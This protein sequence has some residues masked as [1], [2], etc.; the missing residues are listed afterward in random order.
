MRN[1]VVAI[2]LL[3]ATSACGA[4][5]VVCRHAVGRVY[6]AHGP[7]DGATR[8][9]ETDSAPDAVYTIKWQSGQPFGEVSVASG[10][11]RIFKYSASLIQESEQQVTLS[12][13]NPD[14]VWLYSV[15]PKSRLA[16]I[17]QHNTDIVSESGGGAVGS[18]MLA[19]CSAPTS[20]SG[21]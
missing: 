13:H 15:F 12:V 6:G 21:A 1:A 17:S 16:L 8:I 5:E 14:T 9:D 10:G 19:P 2:A 3:L 4:A 20:R 11:G 7:E 18:V